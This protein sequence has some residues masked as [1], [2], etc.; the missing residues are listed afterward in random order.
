MTRL[1]LFSIII[2]LTYS[3]SAY[4]LEGEDEKT[5]IRELVLRQ[6]HYTKGA[7]SVSRPLPLDEAI[8]DFIILNNIGS[9]EDYL[10]WLKTNIR[11]QKD[12]GKETKKSFLYRYRYLERLI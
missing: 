6:E 4:S 1:L 9:L 10:S 5:P 3:A 12:K 2:V 11:Y 7:I 8:R